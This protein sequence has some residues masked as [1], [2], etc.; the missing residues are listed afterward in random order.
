M[1]RVGVAAREVEDVLETLAGL[2]FPVNP[3][4]FHSGGETIIE[5]PAYGHQLEEIHSVLP[6]QTKV[7]T[8]SMLAEIGL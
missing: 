8:V 7:E 3:E 6:E 1:V 5:F 2:D 4:L